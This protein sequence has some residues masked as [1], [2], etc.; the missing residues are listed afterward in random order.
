MRSLKPRAAPLPRTPA[1]LTSYLRRLGAALARFIRRSRRSIAPVGSR[2]TTSLERA[3]TAAAARR[4]PTPSRQRSERSSVVF[5]CA[6][7][8]PC[9]LHDCGVQGGRREQ[10]GRRRD[11]RATRAVTRTARSAADA[12]RERSRARA[13]REDAVDRRTCARSLNHRPPLTRQA[14]MAA[15]KRSALTGRKSCIVVERAGAS[16]RVDDVPAKD[17]ALVVAEILAGFRAISKKYPEVIP[18]LEPVGGS[19]CATDVRDDDWAEEG[20]KRVGF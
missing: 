7:A 10:S 14:K 17:A 9:L 5:L 12:T 18:D 1:P 13:S 11:S 4:R 20:R 6:C 2:S 15:K 8:L 16:I 19:T 3:L